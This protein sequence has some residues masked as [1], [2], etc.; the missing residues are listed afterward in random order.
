MATGGGLFG[1]YKGTTSGAAKI[2]G[3]ILPEAAQGLAD[4]INSSMFPVIL[5]G[6]GIVVVIVVVKVM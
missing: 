6:I 4:W 2:S 3:K 1:I 5:A